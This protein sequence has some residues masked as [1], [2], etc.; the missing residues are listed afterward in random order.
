M[1]MSKYIKLIIVFLV[2]CVAVSYLATSFIT[3]HIDFR[4]WEE[5][6][7]SI[8]VLGSFAMWFG[9]MISSAMSNNS[10]KG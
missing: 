6:Q 5:D 8:C 9:G 7:R 3:L 4:L 2:F 1:T 10:G